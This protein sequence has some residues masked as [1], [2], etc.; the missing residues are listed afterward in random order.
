MMGKE[1]EKEEWSLV[2]DDGG[3]RDGEGREEETQ[4]VGSATMLGQSFI[5]LS[6]FF[7]AIK[8]VIRLIQYRTASKVENS[9]YEFDSHLDQ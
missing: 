9:C 4:W 3:G 7:E 1:W 2:V 5:D 6:F 8:L